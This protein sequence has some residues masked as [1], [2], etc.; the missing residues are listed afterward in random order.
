MLHA[1]CDGGDAQPDA[2]RAEDE[3]EERQIERKEGAGKRNLEPK[4]G[5]EQEKRALHKSDEHGR[6]RFADEDLH[7]GERRD[8]KLIEGALFALSGDGESGEHDD[9]HEGDHGDDARQ[10]GP[11]CD[12]VLVVPCAARQ[13]DG[14]RG[15][16]SLCVPARDDGCC[17]ACGERRCERVVAVGDDLDGGGFAACETRFKVCGDDERHE[18]GL[19]V[20]QRLNLGRDGKR[21]R[22]RKCGRAV[23]VREQALRGFTSRSV[24]DGIGYGV[25]VVVGDV[26]EEQPLGEDGH[27]ECDAHARVFQNGQKLLVPEV[28]EM[29]EEDADALHVHSPTFFR[30]R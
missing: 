17:I 15:M 10:E 30:V 12:L 21:S 18:N 26:A 22:A 29:C 20:D 13:C 23:E 6:K 7:G 2:R 16:Q 19:G 24:D 14:G 8:E 4:K 9:L 25:E 1:A 3:E 11:A 5:N 27:D 28:V